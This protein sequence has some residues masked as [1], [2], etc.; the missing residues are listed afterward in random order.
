MQPD[1]HP[2]FPP[3]QVSLQTWVLPTVREWKIPP[4]QG[5]RRITLPPAV[6]SSSAVWPG[7]LGI[8]GLSSRN[9]RWNGTGWVRGDLASLREEAGPRDDPRGSWSGG[10]RH[11]WEMKIVSGGRESLGI[12]WAT[13]TLPRTL[14]LPSANVPCSQLPA[15]LV[16][17][18]LHVLRPNT[19]VLSLMPF[20]LPTFSSVCEQIL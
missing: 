5:W 2:D 12:L 11:P 3:G 20:F 19:L 18:T 14:D 9:S 15:Q 16:T 1:R 13:R 4:R 8:S 17:A 10:H 6:V 7:S